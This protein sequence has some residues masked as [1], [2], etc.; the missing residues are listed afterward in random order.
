MI[1]TKE[2]ERQIEN[3]IFRVREK[4]KNNS[5]DL[6]Y[7]FIPMLLNIKTLSKE[8]SLASMGLYNQDI[9]NFYIEDKKN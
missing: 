9:N 8:I 7:L 5:K 3:E 6:D 2:I 1:L 4:C